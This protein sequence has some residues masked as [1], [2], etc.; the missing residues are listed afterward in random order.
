L[1]YPIEHIISSSDANTAYIKAKE[2]IFKYTR[3][4]K[5]EQTNITLNKLCAQIEI[6]KINSD[7]VILALSLEN[8]FFINGKETAKN[9]TSF[10]VHSDFVILTTLQHTLVCVPLNEVGLK[11]LSVYD[12]TVKPWLNTMDKMSFT[13]EYIFCNLFYFVYIITF[14]TLSILLQIYI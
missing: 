1:N 13:G 10:Y 9:I 11:Q 6:V 7:D 3:D 12:L 5:F 8:S 4:G 2:Q 14:L